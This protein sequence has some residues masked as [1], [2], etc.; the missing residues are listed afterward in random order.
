MRRFSLVIG[1]L[2]GFAAIGSARAG[3]LYGAGSTFLYPVVAKWAQAWQA[4]GGPQVHFQPIGSTLGLTALREN[5]VDFGV[6]DAPLVDAQLLRDGVAQFPLAVGAIVPVVNLNGVAPGQLRLTGQVLAAIYLGRIRSWDDPAIAALNPGMTLPSRAITVIYRSDGSGTT[7]NWTDYLSKVSPEWFAAVGAATRVAWPVGGGVKGT[8]GVIDAIKLVNGAIGYVE[9]GAATRAGLSV[10]SVQNHAGQFA[11]PNAASF[12]AAI[13]GVDFSRDHDF[14]L[15]LT[16]SRNPG[17]WPIMATSFALVR[18]YPPDQERA[19]YTLMFLKW[20][21][22]KG[23]DIARGLDFIP[24]PLAVA[25][26]LE[27]GGI[28]N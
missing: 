25:D 26:H 16:D 19:R 23:S 13:A 20:C 14:Y 15:R 2:L 11:Q 24:M 8:S 7:Y 9:F 3:E 6:T 22:D 4:A 21:L 28:S 18:S 10:V 5:T 17:A 1:L 12:R 27:A